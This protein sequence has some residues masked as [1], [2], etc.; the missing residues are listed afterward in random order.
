[1][2]QVWKSSARTRVIPGGSWPCIWADVSGV[3]VVS[4]GR[5]LVY[6]ARRGGQAGGRG[7]GSR[8]VV[9]GTFC[10][11][12]DLVL[13]LVNTEHVQSGAVK[14]SCDSWCSDATCLA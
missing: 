5:D 12:C 13:A 10:N 2:S 8:R 4:W 3:L 14:S 11:S 1:M 7:Q 6:A 9:C